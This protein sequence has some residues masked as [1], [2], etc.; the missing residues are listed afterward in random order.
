MKQ[1]YTQGFFLLII[2]FGFNVLLIA[3]NTQVVYLFEDFNTDI[4]S[5]WEVVNN[6]TQD[7]WEWY[8]YLPNTINNTPQ[9]AINLGKYGIGYAGELISP[10]IDC[11]AESVLFLQFWH[12]FRHNPSPNEYGTVD[13]WNGVEWVNLFHYQ[14]THGAWHGQGDGPEFQEINISEYINPELKIR[15]LYDDAGDNGW[16]WAVDDV[17]VYAPDPSLDLGVDFVGPSVFQVDSA[18]YPTAKIFNYGS[19]IV[20][21]FTLSISVKNADQE[22]VYFSEKIIT[23]ADLQAMNS[24]YISMD[25]FWIP[26]A[27]GE[28][29]MEAIVEVENDVNPDNNSLISSCQIIDNMALG[30]NVYSAGSTPQGPIAFSLNDP[31]NV[32]LLNDQEESN[33][34]MAGAWFNETWYGIE[35]ETNRFFKFNNITGER[36]NIAFI[37]LEVNVS[38]MAF[39]YT[40]NTMYIATADWNYFALYTL[41]IVTS[42][43]TFIGENTDFETVMPAM[44]CGLDGQLYL[45][46]FDGNFYKL[47]KNDVEISYVGATGV[48][49]VFY[50]QDIT[51]DYNTSTLYW[52]LVSDYEGALY[53]INIENGSASKVDDFL[54]NMQVTAFCVP[55]KPA[56]FT[57]DVNVTNSVGEP[58]ERVLV[59]IVSPNHEAN[60]FTNEYG[61][62]VL[63]A[64]MAEY[65]WTI[66]HDDYQQK[67][68]V[69]DITENLVMNIYMDPITIVDELEVDIKLY[70]NPAE[71]FVTIHTKSNTSFKLLSIDG[72]VVISGVIEE[73]KYILDLQNIHSGIYF[74]QLEMEEKLISKKIV[75]N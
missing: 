46:G 69:V 12:V 35:N 24:L 56:D 61:A 20:D 25:D 16:C 23:N 36:E 11:S 8:D 75:I 33:Y 15:F 66:S 38:A 48:P 1:F 67:T 22:E 14:E 57:L 32:Y 6:G 30:Y 71:D 45:I 29:L 40:S 59:T 2:L 64:N 68:G 27:I 10:T 3:D 62:A 4:P 21:D 52:G 34:A 26:S 55:Y 74:L 60:Q 47:N 72:K 70:P 65:E 53:K 51:F 50:N 19:I 28:Y 49:E 13:V 5:T 54:G 17:K 9:A 73:P 31:A 41:N 39:D 7:S 37:D 43:I 44:A 18:F 63:F 58:L 42:E